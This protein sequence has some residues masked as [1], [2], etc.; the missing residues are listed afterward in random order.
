LS[1][2]VQ[3]KGEALPEKALTNQAKI[4]RRNASP[5]QNRGFG[6]FFR[7]KWQKRTQ[8]D[9]TLQTPLPTL[10]NPPLVREGKGKTFVFGRGQPFAL[11]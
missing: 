3:K 9:L 1:L 11:S 10:P 4:I 8:V 2:S 5:L 7:V 6:I